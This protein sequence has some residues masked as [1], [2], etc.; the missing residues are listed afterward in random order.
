M[1][2]KDI[3]KYEMM[4]QA[5]EYEEK[6]KVDLGEFFTCANNIKTEVIKEW[7]RELLSKRGKN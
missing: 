5:Y 4:Q 3:D 1:I 7:T 6:Y 2:V